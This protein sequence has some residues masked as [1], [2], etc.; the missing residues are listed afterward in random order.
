[1]QRLNGPEIVRLREAKGMSQVEL[2]RASG[3]RQRS[4]S[5]YES[6]K[7]ANQRTN[8]RG[9]QLHP[10]VPKAIAEA[11]EVELDAILLDPDSAEPDE[12]E[13]A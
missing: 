4:L 10:A 7:V 2:A 13:A 5:G 6:G 3:I 8:P 9:R 12:N 1:M 11:L